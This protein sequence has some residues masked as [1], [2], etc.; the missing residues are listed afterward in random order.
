[1][2]Q[3]DFLV[4]GAQKAGT[5]WLDKM[6]KSHPSIWT[7]AVKELQFFN[8]KFLR[9]VFPWTQ[10]HRVNHAISAVRYAV[11]G[12][13]DCQWDKIK[14]AAHIAD[15]NEVTYEWY[16][17][18]FDYAEK[19]MT[20]GEMTPEYSLLDYEHV[21]EIQYRYPKLKII[22]V[23][24]DPIQRAL[25]GIKMR[26]LQKG[27][28]DSSSQQEIDNF[29]LKCSEDWDVIERSNYKKIISIWSSIFGDDNFLTLLSDELK[30][31]PV[32][33]LKVIGDFLNV[34]EHGF[35]A[36]P[37]ERVH[38][39]KSFNISKEVIQQIEKTQ[40][41]NLEWYLDFKSRRNVEG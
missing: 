16:E 23:M 21:K 20:K 4:I 22:F 3:P 25:S 11:T 14:Q 30:D 19:G 2:S 31:D 28:N 39:G 33:Q 17:A 10:Q 38:V 32:S 24:R 29:V 35:S 37:S 9:D 8:E 6:F 12:D 27:F 13:T 40:K 36:N 1:M 15:S 7:P 18:I 26:L 5:T 41:A 34:D